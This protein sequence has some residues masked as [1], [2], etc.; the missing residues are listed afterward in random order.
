MFF[1]LFAFGLSAVP[2]SALDDWPPTWKSDVAGD[3]PMHAHRATVR[4]V[5]QP[6][7]PDHAV[8]TSCTGVWLGP[9]MGAW[10][11]PA[12]CDASGCSF[13]WIVALRHGERLTAH[14]EALAG[15]QL[16]VYKHIPTYHFDDGDFAPWQTVTLGAPATIEAPVSAWYA[17]GVRIPG[18][19]P[20]RG[21][22]LCFEIASR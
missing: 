2:T 11:T 19:K 3:R 12:A 16:N 20:K 18:M 4:G 7:H 9:N 5:D 17:V 6:I 14:T 1:G 22:S 8:A 21:R 13:R 15:L 10:S